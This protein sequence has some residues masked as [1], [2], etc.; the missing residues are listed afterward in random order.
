MS[1]RQWRRY[2]FPGDPDDHFE[3][4]FFFGF[5]DSLVQH[6]IELGCVLLANTISGVIE[7]FIGS[8]MTSLSKAFYAP[9]VETMHRRGLVSILPLPM[10]LHQL[11][12]DVIVFSRW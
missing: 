9:E 5:N 10:I 8:G 2:L 7:V 1:T 11:V 3:T 4:G 12:G 6:R